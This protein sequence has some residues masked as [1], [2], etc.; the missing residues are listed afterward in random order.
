MT[1]Y[2]SFVLLLAEVDPISKDL[3]RKKNTLMPCS[4]NYIKIVFILL[5]KVLALYI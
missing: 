5:K 3:S 1:F 2:L 4:S